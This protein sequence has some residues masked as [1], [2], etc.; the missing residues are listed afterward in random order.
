MPEDVQLGGGQSSV[1]VS[2]WLCQV[3]AD[4][5]E[6]SRDHADFDS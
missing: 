1:E 5:V 2:G 3:C 6:Q 4:A